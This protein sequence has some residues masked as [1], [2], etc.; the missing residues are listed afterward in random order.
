MT[1]LKCYE[2]KSILK[3]HGI[4]YGYEVFKSGKDVKIRI[5]ADEQDI[6]DYLHEFGFSVIPDTIPTDGYYTVEW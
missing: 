6:L 3:N 4:V 2:L 1:K 5:Y